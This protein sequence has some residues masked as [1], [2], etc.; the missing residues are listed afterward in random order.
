MRSYSSGA[1]TYRYKG[2]GAGL[3]LLKDIVRKNVEE[4]KREGDPLVICRV[5]PVNESEPQMG[6]NWIEIIIRGFVLRE[7]ARVG[8][9]ARVDKWE[10]AR[11]GR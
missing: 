10:L 9:R 8:R 2:G 4:E 7:L 5:R 11:I 6:R 1:S 3:A